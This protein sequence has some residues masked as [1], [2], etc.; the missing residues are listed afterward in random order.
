ML[1]C[2][3]TIASS[4]GG[5][6][7]FASVL[8]LQLLCAECTAPALPR[9]DM[10]PID[11]AFNI[12]IDLE[13]VKQWQE[14]IQQLERYVRVMEKCSAMS[15]ADGRRSIREAAHYRDAALRSCYRS[16]CGLVKQYSRRAWGAF[17]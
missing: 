8:G 15:A 17:W 16:V 13:S 1:S 4:R 5:F 2:R 10:P 3:L 6:L 14:R 11:P 9:I 7:M 12:I